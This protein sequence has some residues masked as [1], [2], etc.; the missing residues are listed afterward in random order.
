MEL[1][2]HPLHHQNMQDVPMQKHLSVELPAKWNYGDSCCCKDVLGSRAWTKL[3]Q[4]QICPLPR[5]QS[6]AEL[7]GKERQ[8][9]RNLKREL[10]RTL[11]SAFCTADSQKKY[12]SVGWIT[13]CLLRCNQ[14]PQRLLWTFKELAGDRG[15]HMEKNHFLSK[16]DVNVLMDELSTVSCE[17]TAGRSLLGVFP[18]FQL[19]LFLLISTRFA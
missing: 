10:K 1:N 8:H 5:G 16:L 19:L 11:R 17:N 18:S 4:L 6:H 12:F 3:L 2:Q 9:A 13:A 14:T 15:I 7:V